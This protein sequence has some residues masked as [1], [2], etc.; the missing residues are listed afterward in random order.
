MGYR[1]EPPMPAAAVILD[2]IGKVMKEIGRPHNQE[3]RGMPRM[4]D[5]SS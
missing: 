1:T 5:F 3:C 2:E 4:F